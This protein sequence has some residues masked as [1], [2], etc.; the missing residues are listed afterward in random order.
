MF[1]DYHIFLIISEKCIQKSFGK[2]IF[3][4]KS[5]LVG[6]GVYDY[7]YVHMG[8]GICFFLDNKK[9]KD[10]VKYNKY[11]NKAFIFFKIPSL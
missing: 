10:K 4:R 5:N 3:C 11:M 9:I 2:L 1:M 7:F 8:M 6:L